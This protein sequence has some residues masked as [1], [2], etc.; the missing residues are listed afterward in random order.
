MDD[1]VKQV[2]WQVLCC[3][4]WPGLVLLLAVVLGSSV[5]IV[6]PGHSGV[7]V[8]LGEVQPEP[9]AEGVHLVIPFVTSVK[10]SSV[11][12]QLCEVNSEGSTKDLQIVSTT[13]ALN[14][15]L[16]REQTPE[17]FQTVGVD[18]QSKIIVP[19]V[20]E[21]FKSQ[22]ARYTAEELVTKREELSQ[23]I[24]TALEER[25][26]ARGLRVE[27]I[28]L[29]D[30]RFSRTFDE[31]VEQKIAAE[32]AA[33]TAKNE[34]EKI[35]VEA[36]KT[37]VTAQGEAD[38]AK[39]RAEGEAAAVRIKTEAE[40]EAVRQLGAALKENQPVLYYEGL[41]KWDGQ[42]PTHVLGT[43]PVPTLDTSK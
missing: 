20:M 16:A 10:M 26:C 39:A 32:Q 4:K 35:R 18:Y 7:V 8:R 40:A 30:F 34:L 14:Y 27:A 12:T 15:A 31:A 21:V 36:E 42:L 22:T 11:Q 29:T 33:L 43:P 25:L 37:V 24:R 41:R 6:P 13:L 19:A 17:L 1:D 23:A 38:A 9:L 3:G 5:T 28:S 2:L